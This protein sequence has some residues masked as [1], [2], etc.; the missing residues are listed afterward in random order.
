M[1]ASFTDT[2][3][4]DLQSLTLY[5]ELQL[6]YSERRQALGH[7]AQDAFVE[8]KYIQKRSMWTAWQNWIE[9]N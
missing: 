6:A 9:T 1:S 4:K 5:N 2:S 7:S 3:T 8:D